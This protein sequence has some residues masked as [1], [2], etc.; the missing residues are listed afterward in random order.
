MDNRL[1]QVQ[2]QM[3]SSATNVPWILKRFKSD[4]TLLEEGRREG[5]QTYQV[6]VY[7]TVRLPASQQTSFD[8][9][10]CSQAP[11]LIKQY[12]T[13]VIIKINP[14]YM[15]SSFLKLQ[16]EHD[17]SDPGDPDKENA[18][19]PVD[20]DKRIDELEKEVAIITGENN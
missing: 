8:Q 4:K 6:S 9:G 5:K 7:A 20:K 12:N 17:G 1:L 14:S 19:E 16:S 15:V 3:P 2:L 11:K 18:P 13:W 10:Q